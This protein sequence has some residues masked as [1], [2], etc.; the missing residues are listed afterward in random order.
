M[1]IHNKVKALVAK[2]APTN[3]APAV[4]PAAPSTPAID[5]ALIAQQQARIADLEHQRA[6]EHMQAQ[7]KIAKLEAEQRA[8]EAEA[9][10]VAIREAARVAARKAGA[11]DEDDAAD[12]VLARGDFKYEKDRIV[13]AADPS[14]DITAVVNET[15]AA[16]PHLLK[17]RT[18]QG[19]GASPF[20]SVPKDGDAPD[21]ST[22]E[23]RTAYARS[24]T[25]EK[26]A[27]PR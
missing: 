17:P 2:K 21:L 14:K 20:P 16:K 7:E 4:A 8:R 26:P 25:L 5:P 22:N 10:R 3:A 13:Y 19:G 15:L 1:S 23:G 24:L 18:P 9:K 11:I 12:L 27:T 6:V